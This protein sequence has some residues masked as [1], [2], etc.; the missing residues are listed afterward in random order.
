M[1]KHKLTI[2]ELLS[3]E[4]KYPILASLIGKI[5]LRWTQIGR[6]KLFLECNLLVM[7]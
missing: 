3:L 1:P 6:K 2:Q 4:N 7:D 5:F